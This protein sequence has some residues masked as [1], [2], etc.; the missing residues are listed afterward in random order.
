MQSLLVGQLDFLHNMLKS[1]L[2]VVF[3]SFA[4]I[5]SCI[6]N[7]I[8]SRKNHEKGTVFPI[9][10]IFDSKKNIFSTITVLDLNLFFFRVFVSRVQTTVLFHKIVFSSV[11]LSL[12]TLTSSLLYQNQDL[13]NI[14]ILFLVFKMILLF[15]RKLQT[16]L[17]AINGNNFPLQL[18]IIIFLSFQLYKHNNELNEK[19]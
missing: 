12:L 13:L 15:I 9:K 18:L 7:V 5:R 14:E 1:N 4:F 8:F 2:K 17:L 19:T 6:E 10:N 16:E 3:F 11:D